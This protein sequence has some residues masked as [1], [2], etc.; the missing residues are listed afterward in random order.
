[1]MIVGR[2]AH[3]DLQQLEQA[4]VGLSQCGSV[5]A[6]I[7]MLAESLGAIAS[8]LGETP[9]HFEIVV[10]AISETK[11]PRNYFFTSYARED[12]PYGPIPAYTLY[13]WGGLPIGGGPEPT[14][15]QYEQIGITAEAFETG[16]AEPGLRLMELL[17]TIPGSDPTN[18]NSV[19]GHWIGGHVDHAVLTAEGVTI[20]R[21]R[22]WPDQP[23]KLIRPEP[24]AA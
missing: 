14:A 17:R 22:E 10:A 3:K 6:T 23:F 11:G 4:I 24:L 21:L 20:T 19:H 2:G 18:P 1:M 13:D 16:L 15:E 5:D 8:D 12:S 9:R 7:D